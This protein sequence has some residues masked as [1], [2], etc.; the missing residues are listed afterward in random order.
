MKSRF[1]AVTIGCLLVLSS[2]AALGAKTDPVT[3]DGG[4]MTVS[5]QYE[6]VVTLAPGE[7][8]NISA[9]CLTGETVLS[10]GPS[11][12]PAGVSIVYSTFIFDGY[13]SGWSVEWVNN[14]TN[15]VVVAPRTAA[16]CTKGTMTLGT[17]Q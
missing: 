8:T 14:T 9:V 4:I 10:G 6:R 12:I 11:A 17:F 5:R 2:G 1:M 3:P 13:R 7:R 15:T 16:I